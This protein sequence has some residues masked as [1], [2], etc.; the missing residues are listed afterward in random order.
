MDFY[1]RDILS[2]SGIPLPDGLGNSYSAG[3]TFVMP[4]NDDTIILY[5]CWDANNYKVYFD[6]GMGGERISESHIYDVEKALRPNTFTKYGYQFVAWSD[7][8]G[9]QEIIIV[10]LKML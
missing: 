1:A 3:K 5:A 6:D 10:M 2:A 7:A 8:Q 9:G 4:V